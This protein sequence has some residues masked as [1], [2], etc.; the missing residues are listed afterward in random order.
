MGQI[1]HAQHERKQ[2]TTKQPEGGPSNQVI[3]ETAK[4]PEGEASDQVSIL[5]YFIISTH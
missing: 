2:E 3:Q 1:V 4:Q 5:K